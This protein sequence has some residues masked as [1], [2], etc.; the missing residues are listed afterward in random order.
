MATKK[1]PATKPE[2]AK[3]TK[4]GSTSVEGYRGFKPVTRATTPAGRP[5][6][7]HQADSMCEGAGPESVE[8]K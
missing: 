5:H 1:P 2:K 8:N 3:K 7:P 4:G 6:A